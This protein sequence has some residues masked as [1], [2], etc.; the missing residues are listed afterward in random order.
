MSAT[1]RLNKV[2][3]AYPFSIRWETGPSRLNFDSILATFVG[4]NTGTLTQYHGPVFAWLQYTD[5]VTGK[6]HDAYTM[7]DI[8]FGDST[9]L[10]QL[11]IQFELKLPSPI[12]VK[13]SSPII[14]HFATPLSG[15][16]PTESNTFQATD[17]DVYY[18]IRGRY[19]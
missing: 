2:L 15:H 16:V 6:Y 18:G 5:P 13:P 1:L 17:W 10:S 19:A 3:K 4:P 12:E 7:L 14:L 8:V 9:S 11:V